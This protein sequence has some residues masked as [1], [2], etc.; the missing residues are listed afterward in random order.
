VA[1]ILLLAL[2]SSG[3]S[4]AAATLADRVPPPAL[5][6]E[7]GQFRLVGDVG[8]VLGPLVAGFLYQE[9]GPGL[10]AAASA[11]V[12]ATAAVV[13]LAWIREP[14]RLEERRR[15]VRRKDRTGELLVD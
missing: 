1:A 6:P 7:L 14:P 11:G 8:L 5:G 9:S 12:F 4:V 2:G 10:A 15:A 13:A 3:I